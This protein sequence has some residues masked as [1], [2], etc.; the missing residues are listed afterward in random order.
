M[1]IS[2]KKKRALYA[3]IREN[4]LNAR[5][6]ITK[7][8]RTG[9]RGAV[10]ADRMDEMLHRLELQIWAKQREVLGIKD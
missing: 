4:V 9:K 2:E 5:I 7:D 3:A 1:R 6:A 10:D 8:W